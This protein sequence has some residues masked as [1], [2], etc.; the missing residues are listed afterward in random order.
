MSVPAIASLVSACGATAAVEVESASVASP[1]AT[2]SP[3]LSSAPL[4]TTPTTTT[5]PTT[6]MTAPSTTVPRPTTTIVQWLDRTAPP[7]GFDLSS[8]SQLA[9]Y[10]NARPAAPWVAANVRWQGLPDASAVAGEGVEGFVENGVVHLDTFC[11]ESAVG[12]CWQWDSDPEWVVWHE[13]GHVLPAIWG[14]G[15]Q[16]ERKAQ[17]VAAAV[18][19]RGQFDYGYTETGRAALVPA[20]EHEELG[21]WQCDKDHT[22]LIR[23]WLTGLGVTV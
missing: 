16:E 17:C 22:T 6:T 11:E 15:A 20:A 8:W 9:G 5:A 1:V 19:G 21:Y 3:T 18:L 23:V 12:L 2:A 7:A 14:E 4:T 10:V 13:V